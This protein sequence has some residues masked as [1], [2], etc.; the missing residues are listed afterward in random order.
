[1]LQ[2]KLKKKKNWSTVEGN[3][4]TLLI[5]QSDMRPG[6]APINKGYLHKHVGKSKGTKL[7]DLINNSSL[8]CLNSLNVNRTKV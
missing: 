6:L 8:L 5:T 1:M 4:Y 7:Y 3:S 2:V